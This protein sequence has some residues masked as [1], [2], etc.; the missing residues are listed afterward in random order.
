[1]SVLKRPIITEKMNLLQERKGLSQYGFEVDIKAKKGE[2][3]A[4]VERVYEVEVNSV[5]T[6]VVR[7]KRR[8][9]YTKRGFISGKSPNYKKAIVTL[10]PGFEIDFYKH[11]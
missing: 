6:I 9:R 11:I 2:I 7:G 5:N 4:E 8:T 10:K 1:M 3:K